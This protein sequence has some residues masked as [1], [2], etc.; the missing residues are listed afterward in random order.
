MSSKIDHDVLK[1]FG[2]MFVG[3]SSVISYHAR[4]SIVLPKSVHLT[5]IKEKFGV[6]IPHGICNLKFLSITHECAN[7]HIFIRT[8]CDGAMCSMKHHS[9]AQDKV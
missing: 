5:V 9:H 6:F 2:M 4:M 7:S 1:L 3:I 8:W